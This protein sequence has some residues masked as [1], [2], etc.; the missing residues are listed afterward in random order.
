M[1]IVKYEVCDRCGEKVSYHSRRLAKVHRTKLTWI[2]CG[3]VNED[4]YQLCGDCSEKL[5]TFLYNRESKNN[6]KTEEIK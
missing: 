6:L 4:E 5:E 3:C 1:A 2:I